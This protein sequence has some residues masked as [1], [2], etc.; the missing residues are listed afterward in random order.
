MNTKN[1]KSAYILPVALALV[2]SCA[3]D[4]FN[5]DEKWVTSVQNAQ[6]TNPTE[7]SISKTS[8]SDT[9]KTVVFTWNVV[10]GAGGYLLSVTN[11]SDP[12]A[13]F[14]VVTDSL[15]DRCSAA[16]I[17]PNEETYEFRLRTAEN[18]K[19][20]NTQATE[21]YIQKFDTYVPSVAIP[22]GTEIASWVAEHLTDSEEEQGIALVPGGHYTLDTLVDF[23]LNIMEF[24]GDKVNRPTVTIGEKGGFSIYGGLKLK[25]INFDCTNAT[26]QNGIINMGNNEE[27]AAPLLKQYAADANSTKYYHDE[28]TIL[29]QGCTFKSVPNAFIADGNMSWCVKDFAIKDC[30]IELNPDDSKLDNT[31]S[32]FIDFHR[33][34]I[35][36]KDITFAN[37]T[38][39]NLKKSSAYF[40]RF[41]NESNASI[42][43]AYGKAYTGLF[44]M[45]HCTLVRC[46]ANGQ[47]GNQCWKSGETISWR[48]CIFYD[49]RYLQKLVRNLS[50]NFT[51]AENVIWGITNTVDNTDKERFATEEDPQF[52]CGEISADILEGYD[53]SKKN[54]GFNLEPTNGMAASLKYGDPRWFEK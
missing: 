10:H 14:A 5:E 9:E 22:D 4:G 7:I 2:A 16:L 19:Y 18:K 33:A 11:I 8:T 12:N 13:P 54:G 48:N 17:L 28:E 49:T 41:K 21:A 44:S 47:F 32:P 40:I 26:K 30:F 36:I 38:F 25:Y 6:L 43:K 20:H 53:F 39:I 52:A 42:T 35:T 51:N 31:G 46:T 1:R 15:I 45:D 24:R 3:D 23:R 27:K 37:S 50:V 34:G 29:V